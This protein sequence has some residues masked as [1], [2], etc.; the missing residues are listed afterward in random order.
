MIKEALNS[1]TLHCLNLDST[2]LVLRSELKE[3]QTVLNINFCYKR[4][5]FWVKRFST[6]TVTKFLEAN[7]L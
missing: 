1:L 7:N 5:S 3:F 4:Y 2:T 6:K